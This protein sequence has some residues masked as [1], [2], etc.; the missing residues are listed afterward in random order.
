MMNTR[1]MVQSIAVASFVVSVTLVVLAFTATRW[2]LEPIAAMAAG[3]A[4]IVGNLACEQ[5]RSIIEKIRSNR[6]RGMSRV[7]ALIALV[8]VSFALASVLP[9]AHSRGFQPPAQYRINLNR[10]P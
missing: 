6:R 5:G 3:V 4:V 9:R 10:I 8:L 7:Q 1:S 2:D